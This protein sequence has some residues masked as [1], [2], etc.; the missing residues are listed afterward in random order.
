MIM[1]HIQM[2]RRYSDLDVFSASMIFR[3]FLNIVC[4]TLMSY[5]MFYVYAEFS[6]RDR[7]GDSEGALIPPIICF[8]NTTFFSKMFQE[9]YR[10][11]KKCHMRCFFCSACFLPDFSEILEFLIRFER[12]GTGT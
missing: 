6:E 10:D 12:I 1:D 4:I 7:E 3:F 8:E 11:V 2:Y 5:S 9:I